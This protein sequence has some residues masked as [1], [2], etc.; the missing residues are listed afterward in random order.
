MFRYELQ[1]HLGD[2]TYGSVLRAVKKGTGE[3]VAIKKLKRT[4]SNFDECLSLREVR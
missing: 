1:G 2:G 3:V 4:F